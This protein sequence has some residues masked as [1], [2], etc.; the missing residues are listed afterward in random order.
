MLAVEVD[1]PHPVGLAIGLQ[2]AYV[3][4]HVVEG[5]AAGRFSGLVNEV[6]SETIVGVDAVTVLMEGVPQGGREF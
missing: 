5:V 2:T 1:G 6:D 3:D 4:G